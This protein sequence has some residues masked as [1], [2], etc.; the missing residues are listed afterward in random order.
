MSFRGGKDEASACTG[1]EQWLQDGGWGSSPSSVN[2]QVAGFASAH[3]YMPGSSV[4]KCV[5][6]R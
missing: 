3:A 4:V 2:S 1:W 5:E 6:S